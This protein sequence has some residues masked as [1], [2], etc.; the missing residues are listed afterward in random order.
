MLIVEA[1]GG[2]AN[3]LQLSGCRSQASSNASQGPNYEHDVSQ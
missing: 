3:V 1:L 2:A